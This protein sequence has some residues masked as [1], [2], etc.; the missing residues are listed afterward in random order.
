VGSARRSQ[1]SGSE[2]P[3]SQ[4]EEEEYPEGPSSEGVDD[5]MDDEYDGEPGGSESGDDEE[6]RL[7]SAREAAAK[8]AAFGDGVLNEGRFR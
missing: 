3:E 8:T 4:G 6:D 7:R 1:Q 5:G 2:D